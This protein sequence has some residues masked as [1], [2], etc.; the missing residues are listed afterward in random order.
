M[1]DQL[2][3]CMFARLSA[4]HITIREPATPQGESVHTKSAET[5]RANLNPGQVRR[6]KLQV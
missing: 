4:N 5:H 2:Y 6:Y 1:S 3:I